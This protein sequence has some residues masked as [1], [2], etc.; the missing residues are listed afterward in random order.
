MQWDKSQ[1]RELLGLFIC[2]CIALCPIVAHNIAQNTPDNF[3]SYPTDNHHCS[4]DVYMWEGGTVHTTIVV[5]TFVAFFQWKHV[6]SH[7]RSELRKVLFLAPSVCGFLFVYE[8]SWQPLNGFVPNSQGRRVRSL[9]RTS[10][11][12]KVK[13][14]R[15]RSPL[16]KKPGIFRSFRWPACGLCLVKQL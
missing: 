1:S 11:K 15:S 14:Q 5:K 4:D 6:L 16:T 12:V 3:P 10:L 13:G 7:A 2:V 8:I 9:A